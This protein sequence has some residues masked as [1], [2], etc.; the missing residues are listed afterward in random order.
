MNVCH[1]LMPN[2]HRRRRRDATVEFSRVGVGDSQLAHDDCRRVRSHR[3]HDA[4]RLA[5]GKFVQTRRNCRQLVANSVYT[6]PT[7]LNSTV[8]SRTCRSRRCV[9]GFKRWIDAHDTPRATAD[10]AASAYGQLSAHR[11]L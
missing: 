7:R 5:V 4:T 1:R 10:I 9:L 8:A 11:H 2:T 6:R 3:R